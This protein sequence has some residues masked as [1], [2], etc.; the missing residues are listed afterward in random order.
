[1]VR[2]SNH[3]CL[4]S[5]RRATRFAGGRRAPFEHVPAAAAGPAEL[6]RAGAV[7]SKTEFGAR[8]PGLHDRRPG[9]GGARPPATARLPPPIPSPKNA[10]ATLF[11]SP[12]VVGPRRFIGPPHSPR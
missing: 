8:G 5:T 9:G 11:S 3:G 2:Q 10:P 6:H 1:M 7:A 12:R 4:G